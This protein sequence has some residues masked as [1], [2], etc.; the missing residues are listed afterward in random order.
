[1]PVNQALSILDKRSLG[2]RRMIVKTLGA[3]GRGHLGPAFSLVEIIRALYDH[4]LRYDANNPSW[5]L[6]DRFILSKGHG[7]VALYVM[8]AEKG[9]FNEEEL[10]KLCKFEGL[11]GGHPEHSTPG[12]EVSTGS[13]GH[14]LPIGTGMALHARRKK[15]N[16][17]VFVVMG[18]G[19]LGE[20][21]VWEA[22]MSASKHKLSNLTAI[23]DYNK[24]QA[25][26]ST[27]EVLDLEP[28]ADKWR[29]FGF[30]TREADGHDVE[31][32][33]KLFNAKSESGKPVA[34]ICHTVKGRGASFVENNMEWHHKNKIG[35]DEVSRLME[36]L[37]G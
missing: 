6:R 19:E 15:E 8:L 32:L 7:C 29:S 9:F 31:S 10:W 5:P 28:L 30:E 20:G 16:H 2:L 17:R 12:V 26:G 23:V 35:Q 24:S 34:V 33:A 27:F 14:G 1:M 22:A 25:Y 37:E 21:S 18:D 3:A 36:A 13:L 4:V 11:L